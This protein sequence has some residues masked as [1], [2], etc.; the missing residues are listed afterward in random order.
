MGRFWVPVSLLGSTLLG[1]CGDGGD[2]AKCVPG[3]TVA[4]P[5]PTGQSGSQTCTSEGTFAACTCVGPTF[6]ASGPGGAGGTTTAPPSGGTGGLGGAPFDAPN[7]GMGGQGPALLDAGPAGMGGQEPVLLDGR[8]AGTG[9]VVGPVTVAVD[10]SEMHEETGPPTAGLDGATLADL[11]GQADSQDVPSLPT[12][13][14]DGVATPAETCDD[15]NTLGGDG[16]SAACRVEPGFKCSGSPS[17]CSRT[18]CGDGKKEGSESCDDG[19]TVPFDG[20]SED[21]QVEPACKSGEGC[22]SQCGDGIVLGEECDDGN[23][24][25]GDGCSD[26]CKRELGWTCTQPELGDK[27]LVPVIY[28]DFRY[29]KPTDFESGV[30]GSYNPV[31]GI[32]KDTLDAKGKPVYAGNVANAHIAS[33][34]TFSQWFTDVSGVNH[35]TASKMSLW[36]DG[37]GSYVNRYGANGEQWNTTTLAD[38]CGTVANA[39]LDADGMPIPC[40]SEGQY[41]PHTNPTGGKTDCQKME[42]QG[43]TQLPGSC[44]SDN[45]TYKAYYVVSKADGNP[46][47]FPVDGDPFTPE[48][49]RH[50]ATI[51]PYYDATATWPKDKDAGGK[52]RL[53]NFSFTSEVRYW[54]LYSKNKSYTLDFVAEDDVW[55]FI[56]GK[57]AVDLGGVHTPVDGQFVIG[58]NGNGSTTVTATYPLSPAPTPT[59]QT[60]NLGL[61]DGRVYEIAIFQAQ[62]QTDGSSFRITLPAFNTAPSK[63]MPA[64]P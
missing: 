56:N 9:G 4:C 24:A 52:E 11:A 43:Y 42:D 6:D 2:G 49:E 8:P 48:S 22:A 15:G 23:T 20:C 59:K 36:N 10:A 39:L 44:F 60:A 26:V 50:Y 54:F 58:A 57:L 47:F 38:N 55:V 41:D 19:N 63:C 28:R 3:L 53:H 34:D 40:T 51:P 21:C 61:Q 7:A 12:G 33:V 18:T 35:S 45:G 37:K 17:K 32:V 64:L 13:C 1:G 5:C 14:G 62:R 27:I 29:G 16:C 46:L 25:N 31:T 30:A